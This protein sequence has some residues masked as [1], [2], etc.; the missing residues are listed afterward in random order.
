MSLGVKVKAEVTGV[1]SG[2]VKREIA[3]C[4]VCN[5]HFQETK[6]PG[7]AG[8]SLTASQPD[9]RPRRTRNTKSENSPRRSY[10]DDLRCC[11]ERLKSFTGSKTDFAETTV[12]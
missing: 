10:S 8:K 1:N 4:G 7:Y 5:L 6:A 3:K 2:G 11:F 12:A 9:L